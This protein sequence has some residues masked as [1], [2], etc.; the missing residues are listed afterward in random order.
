MN[1]LKELYLKNKQIILY[2][3]FGVVTTVVSIAVCFLTLKIG[4]KFINDGNGQPN[5]LLDVIGSTTQWVSGVI[6][7]FFTNKWWV[8]TEAEKG[9]RAGIKQFGVFAGSRI[10]TYFLEVVINLLI[11]KVFELCG[12]VAVTLTIFKLGIELTSRFW[13][14]M[15]SAV[16]VV[17]SNYY[18]SKLL[19]FKEKK[20]SK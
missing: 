10:G 11:I 1:K 9:R 18:I 12:Y 20:T 8:F 2:L 4:V 6:V 7:A 3:F 19:V 14:K 5:E 15:I 13:A 16:L 17:I